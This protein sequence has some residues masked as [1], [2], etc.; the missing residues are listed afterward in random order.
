M[1][2]IKLTFIAVYNPRANLT[3]RLNQSVKKILY[4][5]WNDNSR[6]WDEITLAMAVFFYNIAI[7]STTEFSPHFIFLCQKPAI[8]LDLMLGTVNGEFE[9]QEQYL[10]E[11]RKSIALV[12]E[13][14]YEAFSKSFNLSGMR[15]FN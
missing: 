8:P 6:E 1:N 9:T 10:D 13:K 3:E 11:L 14:A 5:L 2:S 15:Q 12:P 4:K 7:H